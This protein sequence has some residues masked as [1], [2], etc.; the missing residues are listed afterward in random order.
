[1]MSRGDMMM[2]E[3]QRQ[4]LAAIISRI[5]DCPYKYVQTM[6][7]D[8][9]LPANLKKD[10]MARLIALYDTGAEAELNRL[11]SSLKETR[12]KTRRVNAQG[13]AGH[14]PAYPGYVTTTA[15]ADSASASPG[16][17]DDDE[18]MFPTMAVEDDG[19]EDYDPSGKLKKPRG[20]KTMAPSSGKGCRR[21]SYDMA[22]SPP[23]GHQASPALGT[24]SGL[25]MAPGAGLPQHAIAPRPASGPTPGCSRM[26]W[27]DEAQGPMQ[28]KHAQ[29]GLAVAAARRAVG[30]GQ[31]QGLG[32]GL[33]G[34]AGKPHPHQ[35]RMSKTGRVIKPRRDG[36]YV[37]A[38]TPLH[39]SSMTYPPAG[40]P[41]SVYRQSPTLEAGGYD[42]PQVASQPEG[43]RVATAYGHA[44]PVQEPVPDTASAS[45][46]KSWPPVSEPPMPSLQPI[47]N[48]SFNRNVA[49]DVFKPYNGQHMQPKVNAPSVFS[50]PQEQGYGETSFVPLSQQ[51]SSEEVSFHLAPPSPSQVVRPIPLPAAPSNDF[52]SSL[53]WLVNVK[54]ENLQ[55]P[56]QLSPYWRPANTNSVNSYRTP[57]SFT[58]SS[59]G[60]SSLFQDHS[61]PLIQPYMPPLS[62]NPLYQHITTPNLVADSLHQ[63]RQYKQELQIP[64]SAQYEMLQVEQ[65]SF[66]SMLHPNQGPPPLFHK[67]TNLPVEN[68]RP[69][70]V[71]PTN[72]SAIDTHQDQ[73]TWQHQHH[74]EPWMQETEEQK[75]NQQLGIRKQ[76]KLIQLE[77][78]QKPLQLQQNQK[79]H[80]QQYPSIHSSRQTNL[81]GQERQSSFQ[82][83]MSSQLLHTVASVKTNRTPSIPCKSQLMPLQ[84]QRQKRFIPSSSSLHPLPSNH[85]RHSANQQQTLYN[86]QPGH[87]MQ[88]FSHQTASE[89]QQSVKVEHALGPARKKPCY[90][91][92]QTTRQQVHTGK[93]IQNQ[94]SLLNQ[95]VSHSHQ[96]DVPNALPLPNPDFCQ[97]N[98]I[99]Y[100]LIYN[101]LTSVEKQ[102]VPG[103]NKPDGYSESSRNEDIFNFS[104][105]MPVGQN[106]FEST[107]NVSS[108]FIEE[109]IPGL[110]QHVLHSSEQKDL[111]NSNLPL[112]TLPCSVSLPVSLGCKVI[113][114]STMEDLPQDTYSNGSQKASSFDSSHQ[115]D[116]HVSGHPS[117]K[118]EL[119]GANDKTSV[120]DSNNAPSRDSE[121]PAVIVENVHSID[122]LESHNYAQLIPVPVE[123]NSLDEDSESNRDMQLRLIKALADPSSPSQSRNVT[124]S[125]P[126]KID[127]TLEKVVKENDKTQQVIFLCSDGTGEPEYMTLSVCQEDAL[128]NSLSS[129]PGTAPSTP[130]N[131]DILNS[132]NINEEGEENSPPVG[133]P[134]TN[135]SHPSQVSTIPVTHS[136]QSTETASSIS[137]YLSQSRSALDTSTIAQLSDEN[138]SSEMSSESDSLD[139]SG[140]SESENRHATE[141]P[142]VLPEDTLLVR[143]S[144]LPAEYI[145]PTTESLNSTLPAEY[146]LPTTESLNSTL[147]ADYVLPP[148]ENFASTLPVSHETIN[149]FG[150]ASSELQLNQDTADNV[151]P[152]CSK[153]V[154]ENCKTEP[155]NCQVPVRS[156]QPLCLVVS[157]DKGLREV[158]SIHDKINQVKMETNVDSKSTVNDEIDNHSHIDNES[159]QVKIETII[160][161]ESIVNDKIENLD[162]QESQKF[163]IDNE[164]KSNTGI[165]CEV[166][167]VAIEHS[168]SAAKVSDERSSTNSEVNELSTEIKLEKTASKMYP[169]KQVRQPVRCSPRQSV[170]AGPSYTQMSAVFTQQK[171]LEPPPQQS[172]KGRKPCPN[173]KHGCPL[174]LPPAQLTSHHSV[175]EYSYITCPAIGCT[176]E[177]I[178]KKLSSH[179]REAHRSEIGIG[180]DSEHTVFFHEIR[181]QQ[182]LTFLREVSRKL[183]VICIHACDN[184]IFATMQ[185]IASG[186][187]EKPILATGT[188]EVID[189]G[190]SPHAWRGKIGP[191]Q[192]KLDVVRDS[193]NCLQIAP[194]ILGVIESA[195]VT[196]HTNIRVNLS[197]NPSETSL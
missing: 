120:K 103:S 119:N 111:L 160:E 187:S 27:P 191:I 60:R 36:S 61:R 58:S 141:H 189:E 178:A 188:L 66:Y 174:V 152:S 145:L 31:G 85:Y 172:A 34:Q 151:V 167:E 137:D 161:T 147:P 133:G 42:S 23:Q 29:A 113:P 130:L 125:V 173:L 38:K 84:S 95:A 123:N 190:G 16:P 138:T 24:S 158:P 19:D 65:A 109:V 180:P 93:Q 121:F 127:T 94:T 139:S 128:N 118:V 102:F 59:N 55:M 132:S 140:S 35:A 146:I 136:D 104:T 99:S 155:S 43:F 11:L 105:E 52:S 3:P 6:A 64:P 135:S 7:T 126:D 193:G 196:L 159:S 107:S 92:S 17:E 28:M 21:S 72:Q 168:E 96:I 63:S 2:A 166:P 83:H 70:L 162:S 40:S 176:W 170:R 164:N 50:Y 142:Q 117:E 30:L 144:T 149:E 89:Y 100:P 195:T 163:H 91:P 9:K 25:A 182:R 143:D 175:C 106:S 157:E 4:P 39:P 122:H 47:S 129:L 22:T 134:S 20:G 186:R 32:Q 177:C 97:D 78:Q 67:S 44:H 179:I 112:A 86:R 77:N 185:Y 57:I 69:A 71:S 49:Q 165:D 48:N 116:F 1:M 37:Y 62:S 194:E 82:G 148:A 197:Q 98:E 33:G 156:P 87:H 45:V 115:V 76:H 56:L 124:I 171:S 90:Q 15:E 88:R 12:S 131:S 153:S 154:L 169:G 181:Q 54:S 14:S 80:H 26:F 13:G 79:N 81:Q 110:T 75:Y 10:D 5:K 114:H 150:P 46:G 41:S 51:I 53:E 184:S 74:M 8:R 108:A 101:Y 192:Q 68:L 18:E 183:F 73:Q